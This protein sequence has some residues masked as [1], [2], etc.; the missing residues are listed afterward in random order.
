MPRI[1][2]YPDVLER[3]RQ[4][5][6]VC[7]YFNSGAFGFEKSIP[8]YVAGWIGAEDPTIRPAAREHAQIVAPPLAAMLTSLAMRAWHEIFPGEIWLMPKSQWAYELDFGS[9]TW[10]PDALKLAGVDPTP[11]EGHTDSPAIEF[12]MEELDRV[13]P[14]VQT[15]IENLM[16]SDFALA[17]PTF[18]VACTLHNHRQIW[19]LSNDKSPI[20]ALKSFVRNADRDT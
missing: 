14:L 17:F 3:M 6:M 10:L 8:I 15:L 9:R 20:D 13:A 12:S 5:G 7:Q 4:L 2:A 18:P 1:I 16:G 19:W 11:L